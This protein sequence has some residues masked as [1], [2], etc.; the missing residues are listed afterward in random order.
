M[1]VFMSAHFIGNWQKNTRFY[2]NKTKE[3]QIQ[4]KSSQT[5]LIFC[6]HAPR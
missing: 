1:A 2:L 6:G 5:I 3:L 4:V